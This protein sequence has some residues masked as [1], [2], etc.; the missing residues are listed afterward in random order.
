MPTVA[1]LVE[2]VV[3]TVSP[4]SRPT[5]STGIRLL[6]RT[7][8]DRPLTAVTM[9]HLEALH[10]QVRQRTGAATV[11][12][13][14]ATGR[15]LPSC[16]P[17]SYMRGAAENFVRAARFFFGYACKADLLA[18]SPADQLRPP[19]RGKAPERP[20]TAPELTDIWQI[21]TTTGDDPE[22]DGLL[23]AFLRHSAAR[24]EGAIN[25]TLDA[26]N[27]HRRNL[28]LTEKNGD[29]RELPTA[30][31]LLSDLERFARARGAHRPSDPVLRYRTGAP[32]TRRRF[33]TLFDRVDREPGW[34]EPL[35]V[36]AHWIRHTT[37]ADI[38]A[39]SDIRVAAAFAGHQPETLGVIGRDT[40]VTFDDLFDAYEAVFGSRD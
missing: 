30:A 28:V 1:D 26:L 25:L 35:Q 11:A 21:A 19:R 37:L 17:D 13:A 27:G 39:V 12:R 24:R 18:H 9:A 33:N 16:D 14:R 20:L 6:A 10:H 32:L 3:A 15:R 7:L 23:L 4:K 5:Y 40:Q 31:W 38:A 22:L 34:T 2:D 8:A 36:G 29:T